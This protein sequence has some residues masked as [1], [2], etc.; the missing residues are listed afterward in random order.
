MESHLKSLVVPT[1]RKA[2]FKGAFPHF[3]RLG[4]DRIDLLTFQFDR[5]GGGI[6]ITI[7]QC[8]VLG[9][10]TRS[11]EVVGPKVVSALDLPYDQSVRLEQPPGAQGEVW[12]RFDSGQFTHCAGQVLELLPEAEGWWHCKATPNRVAGGI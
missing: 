10:T 8:G 2:G 5:S 4:P 7:S 6:V 1:L 3:R 11:G 9:A 12:L